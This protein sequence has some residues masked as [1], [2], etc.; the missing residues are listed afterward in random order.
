MNQNNRRPCQKRTEI[1]ASPNWSRQQEIL[2]LENH[3]TSSVTEVPSP[4]IHSFSLCTLNLPAAR[5]KPLAQK[6]VD[7]HRLISIQIFLPS[8]MQSRV[9]L[10]KIMP[11]AKEKKMEKVI[12]NDQVKRQIHMHTYTHLEKCFL[13][14]IRLKD[15][16]KKSF[17]NIIDTW[18]IT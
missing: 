12:K 18:N 1:Q 8:S 10:V 14:K 4:Q 2:S 9:S 15:K 5:V 16:E 17:W 7:H 6:K 13:Q 11:M 3:T